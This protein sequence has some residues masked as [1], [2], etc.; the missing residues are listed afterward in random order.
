MDFAVGSQPFLL[1]RKHKNLG[2]L[3][4]GRAGDLVSGAAGGVFNV[5]VGGV[6]AAEF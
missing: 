5:V 6:A 4:D 2:L 1:D 3:E